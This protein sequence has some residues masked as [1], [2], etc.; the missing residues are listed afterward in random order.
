MPEVQGTTSAPV[1]AR[2]DVLLTALASAI[3]SVPGV[4]RLEPTLSTSG[5]R[6]LLKPDPTDGIHLL[7]RTRTA[8]VDVNVATG[9]TYQARV[10]AHQ[11]QAAIARTITAAGYARGSITVSIL[12][13][14]PQQ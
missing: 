12:T 13:I 5:P 10:V 3:L 14:D 2:R 8:D 9:T 7:I 1:P 6:A 11:V 4:V